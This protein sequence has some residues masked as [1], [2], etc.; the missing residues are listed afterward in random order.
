MIEIFLF[1][2]GLVYFALMPI[3]YFHYKHLNKTSSTFP[4]DE[5]TEDVL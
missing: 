1:I 3:S 4:D 5:E 2:T